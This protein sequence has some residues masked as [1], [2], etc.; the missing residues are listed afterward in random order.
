M[1]TYLF[2][3]GL[4]PVQEWISQ[5]RRSRDL[6]AGSVLLCHLMAKVLSRLSEVGAEIVV[7]ASPDPALLTHLDSFKKA[8]DVTYGIPHRASGY[9]ETV[10]DGAAGEEEVRQIFGP[11]EKT[12]LEETWG[13]LKETY[14]RYPGSLLA[15]ADP[16]EVDASE[17]AWHDWQRYSNRQQRE[18]TLRGLVGKVVLRG[19]LAPFAALLRTAE[20]LHVGKGA[21]FGLGRIEVEAPPRG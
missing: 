2:S 20:V 9:F 19:D 5:A 3:L 11:L 6:R 7:P 15:L 4:I 21:T 16:V 10:A 17:L 18:M 14:L 13:N 8:L 1:A 12:F